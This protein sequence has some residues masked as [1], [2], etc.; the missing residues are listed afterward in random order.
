MLYTK[1]RKEE[2]TKI[3]VISKKEI[4]RHEIKERDHK[5]NPADIIKET[6]HVYE[7]LC[8]YE[9]CTHVYV[10]I[11]AYICSCGGQGKTLEVLLHHSPPYLLQTV[12]LTGPEAELATRKLE[13]SSCLCSLEHWIT[14]TLRNI[15]RILLGFWNFELMSPG[16]Y[17]CFFS[18]EP[19]TQPFKQ[20]FLLF[21]FQ[22]STKIKK[23]SLARLRKKCS[24]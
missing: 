3:K 6:L 9:V 8:P 19:F 1:K 15:P 18:A 5:K 23:K 20:N 10:W 14:G 12:S 2:Q 7:F 17:K 13:Q 11:S 4:L 16:L 24:K 21:S 22:N